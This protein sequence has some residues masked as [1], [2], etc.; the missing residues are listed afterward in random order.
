MISEEEALQT[1]LS[2]VQP[3]RSRT[4][5]LAR[6][7]NAYAAQDVVA[8]VA[9]P[10]FDNSAMDGYAVVAK[11]TASGA[12]L[13]IV[14]E[15]PAGLDQHLRVQPGEAIR[16]F[17]GAPMPEGADAVVM[18]EETRVEGDDVIVETSIEA[19]EFVR[20]RGGDVAEGQKLVAAGECI[21]P[22]TL[23]VLAAQG[24]PNIG[25]G[26]KVH[27]A[28]ISTGDE[29]A[30]PG[31][32]LKPGQIYEANSVL[33]RALLE[34]LGAE[35]VSTVH[36]PDQAVAIQTSLT[37]AVS[38]NVV[39]ITGG[40]SVGARD[41]V[42][43]ALNDVGATLDLWRVALKPG[44]PFLFGH[45]KES[46][47]FGLPGNPVSAFVTFLLFVRPAVLKLMGASGDSLLL[48][49]VNARLG[50][51]IENP[52]ERPHYVRGIVRDDTFMPVGRQESHALF[53][54]SRA[55]A[56]VRAAP[57]EDIA[58]GANICAFTW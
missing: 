3:L 41:L 39:I 29:L 47:I 37:A 33:L 15:Q 16:I 30:E 4:L 7:I 6:A 1:I 13:K 28:I 2:H 44:K 31:T 54:L 24:L 9:L 18:Q 27:A 14:G 21:R 43:A 38:C 49:R 48:N 42:K 32:T 56:L 35:V 34:Q 10:P 12:R 45:V 8:R 40:V 22:Q 51:A 52:G 53:G 58:A 55:N 5:P 46:A 11:S 26:G 50:E 25:V 20:R 36:C 19:G 57:G 23:A 17:T